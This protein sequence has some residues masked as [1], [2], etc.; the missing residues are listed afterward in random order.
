V[1]PYKKF[2]KLGNH[3][4]NSIEILRIF[5][6][7]ILSIPVNKPILNFNFTKNSADMLQNWQC[8]GDAI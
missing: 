2:D 8:F 3:N 7:Q 4:E 1:R 6:L 5:L